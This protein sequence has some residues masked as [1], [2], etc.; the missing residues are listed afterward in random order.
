[1]E[2]PNPDSMRGTKK[3]EAAE[4]MAR[5]ILDEAADTEGT[6]SDIKPFDK[7]PDDEEVEQ[8]DPDAIKA[9]DEAKRLGL[10]IGPTMH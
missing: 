5:E 3:T 8:S 9:D 2:H 4:M 1:M 10:D 6:V 7:A